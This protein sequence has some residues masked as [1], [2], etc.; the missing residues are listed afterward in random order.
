[1][2]KRAL[3]SIAIKRLILSVLMGLVA[4]LFIGGIYLIL[5]G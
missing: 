3:W 2:Y 1:M 5:G 4:G